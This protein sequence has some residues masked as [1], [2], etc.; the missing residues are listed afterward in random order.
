M[1]LSTEH[2]PCLLVYDIPSSYCTFPTLALESHIS[3]RHLDSFYWRMGFRHQ[4]MSIR[5]TH[6]YWLVTA[7][8]PSQTLDRKERH[9]YIHNTIYINNTLINLFLYFSTHI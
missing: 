3:P 4:D 7:M 9:I 5:C 2:F 6:Y 8:R 1:S